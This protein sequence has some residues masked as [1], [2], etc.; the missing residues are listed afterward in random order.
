MPEEPVYQMTDDRRQ[1]TRADEKTKD[2]LSALSSLLYACPQALVD[3]EA[4]EA[5]EMWSWAERGFLSR[6]GGIDDQL[7]HDLQIIAIVSEERALRAEKDR[8]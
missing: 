4:L 3:E 2:S 5:L 6:S 7:N 8:P 1:T